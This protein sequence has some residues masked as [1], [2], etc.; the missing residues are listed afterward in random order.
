MADAARAI[1]MLPFLVS[2]KDTVS[3]DPQFS[4]EHA[5]YVPWLKIDVICQCGPTT[6]RWSCRDSIQRISSRKTDNLI[7]FDVGFRRSLAKK[8]V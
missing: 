6:G 1:S 3:V 7:A 2:I 5:W 8:A 4:Y